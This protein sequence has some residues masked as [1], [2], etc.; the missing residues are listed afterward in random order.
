MPQRTRD[1][2][3]AAARTMMGTPV[4]AEEVI[5]AAGAIR[6]LSLCHE[7]LISIAVPDIRAPAMHQA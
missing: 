3:K 2:L 4:F 1:A 7:R 6:M 5:Y